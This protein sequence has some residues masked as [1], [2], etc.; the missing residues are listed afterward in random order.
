MNPFLIGAGYLALCAW[1]ISLARSSHRADEM[2]SRQ[3]RI[4]ALAQQDRQQADLD[5][6]IFE[7]WARE[8]ALRVL[9]EREQV[10]T[11]DALYEAPAANV[12]P[13]TSARRFRR[14]DTGSAA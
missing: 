6:A 5:E 4:A 7:V 1:V 13:I 8:H 2:A 14:P 11:L 3:A 12:V 10:A 9:R